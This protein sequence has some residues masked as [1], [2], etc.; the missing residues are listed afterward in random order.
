MSEQMRQSEDI[1]YIYLMLIGGA[2]VSF[3]LPFQSNKINEDWTITLSP[4]AF[5][6]GI[7]CVVSLK[8]DTIRT[9]VAHELMQVYFNDCKPKSCIDI[10]KSTF[11]HICV[12]AV[13]LFLICFSIYKNTTDKNSFTKQLRLIGLT[14]ALLCILAMCI[15][16]YYYFLF[17][18]IKNIRYVILNAMN[19][20]A[21][22][23][24]LLF[25]TFI[26]SLYNL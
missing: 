9:P 17:H 7:L 8:I 22:A 25:A 4:I 11:Y 23:E 20:V 12:V 26:Y 21:F 3:S 6:I 13:I 1:S 18:G 19:I 16:V 24:Y 14:S 15:F 5:F 10:L 2:L